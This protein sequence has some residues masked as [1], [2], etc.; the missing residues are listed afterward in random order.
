MPFLQQKK[1]EKTLHDWRGLL[2]YVI[3]STA[4]M[5]RLICLSIF[6]I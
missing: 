3:L 1:K 4:N 5:T 6:V 2:L